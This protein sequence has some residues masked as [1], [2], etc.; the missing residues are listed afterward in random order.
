M[1]QSATMKDFIFLRI[2]LNTRLCAVESPMQ[3]HGRFA[4]LNVGMFGDK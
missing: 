2:Y 3:T 1:S 4:V